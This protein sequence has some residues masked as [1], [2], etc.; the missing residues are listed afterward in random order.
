MHPPDRLLPFVARIHNSGDCR[1]VGVN[2][3]QCLWR[4]SEEPGAG[5]QNF[6]NC[7]VLIGDRRDDKVGPGVRN[8]FTLCGPGVGHDRHIGIPDLWTNF[9][10]ILRAGDQVRETSKVAQNYGSAGLKRNHAAGS[11]THVC[12]LIRSLGPVE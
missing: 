4:E 5:L 7:L 3:I 9:G 8:L 10:T 11:V 6:S 2:I 1:D 12:I